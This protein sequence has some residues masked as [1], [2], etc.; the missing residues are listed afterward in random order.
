MS[1]QPK[2][3]ENEIEVYNPVIQHTKA[4]EEPVTEIFPGIRPASSHIVK[5]HELDLDLSPPVLQTTAKIQPNNKESAKDS[6]KDNKESENTSLISVE[7]EEQEQRLPSPPK[8]IVSMKKEKPSLN[9][10]LKSYF[11]G[12]G[13]FSPTKQFFVSLIMLLCESSQIQTAYNS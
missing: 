8:Q 10:I 7:E 2:I 4:K 12:F 5:Q 13:Q 6:F 1:K 9:S 11:V 3:I